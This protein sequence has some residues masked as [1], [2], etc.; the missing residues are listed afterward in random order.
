MTESFRRSG[1]Y[2]QGDQQQSAYTQ[3][4][5][6]QSAYPQQPYASAH[7]ASSSSDYSTPS[8][9]SVNPEW[10]PPPAYEPAQQGA[11]PT[12]LLTE[13]VSPAPAAPRSAPRARSRCSPPWR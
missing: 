10:P 3:G 13:P 2:P 8:A 12:A 4:D 11:A 1:E 7:P 5:A 9:S 6:Q